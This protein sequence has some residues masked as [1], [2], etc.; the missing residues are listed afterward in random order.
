MLFDRR[1]AERLRVLVVEP[2]DLVAARLKTQL[3]T[4]GHWVL[5]FARDGEEAVTAAERLQPSLI[6]MDAKLPGR[7]GIDTARTILSARPVPIVLL[8]GYTGAELVRRAR[9]AGVVAYLTSV[10]QRQLVSAISVALERFGESRILLERKQ[11]T[12]RSL[13]ETTWTIIEAEEVLSRHDFARCL[14]TIFNALRPNPKARTL[15]TRAA[16]A[17]ALRTASPRAVG[18]MI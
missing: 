8:T 17:T 3:E 11:S 14:E 9:E 6:L 7:D 13:R 4:L 18:S 15:S 2:R 12:R 5:G 10:D 16:R 1:S